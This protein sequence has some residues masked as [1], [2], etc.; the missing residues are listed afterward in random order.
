MKFGYFMLMIAL[1]SMFPAFFPIIFM[2]YIWS[3]I[4]YYFRPTKESRAR[5]A[6]YHR[7]ESEMYRSIGRGEKK[8]SDFPPGYPYTGEPK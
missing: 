7:K 8:P 3:I 6:E 1:C 5:V 4:I 2:S